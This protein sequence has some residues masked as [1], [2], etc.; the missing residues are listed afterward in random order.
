VK[1]PNFFRKPAFR[2]SFSGFICSVLMFFAWKGGV[3]VYQEFN[4]SFAMKEF[5]EIG[6]YG[7]YKKH[8]FSFVDQIDEFANLEEEN[9]EL[10]QKLALLERDQVLQE[11]KGAERDLASLNE[12][13]EENLKNDAGSELATALNTIKYEI[14]TH[15]SSPQL[16]SLAI[17]HFKKEDFEKSAIIFHHLLTLKEDA[18]YRKPENFMIS[19]ISWYHLNNFH[20]AMKDIKEA[21]ALT[22]IS[23]PSHRSAMIWEAVTLKALGKKELSQK[24]LLKYLET[25]PH[26]DEASVI[27]GV[28]APASHTEEKVQKEHE[29]HGQE[30]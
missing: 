26:T 4:D 13:L 24:T 16:Y 14:P 25:Y 21:K 18:Q 27:N 30:E 9:Q 1:S 6:V 12:T 2:Y 11:A 7:T 3:P 20:L 8:L 23:D 15:L 10:N 29:H 5:R 17:G 22:V 19:G 28:R